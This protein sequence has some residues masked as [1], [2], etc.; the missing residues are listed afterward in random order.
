MTA[1]H[2]CGTSTSCVQAWG[3]GIQKAKSAIASALTRLDSQVIYCDVFGFMVDLIANK[4]AYGLTQPTTSYCDGNASS[5]DDHWTDC[6]VDGHADWYLWMSFV[7]HTTRVHRL[8]A[9]DMKGAVD[10]HL[11]I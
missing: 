9:L 10:A 6:M 1:N 3:E 5:L 2:L 4:D 7:K 8:I 11:G